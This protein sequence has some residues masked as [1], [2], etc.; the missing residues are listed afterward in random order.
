MEHNKVII[1]DRDGVI[2]VNSDSY[3]KSI[4]ELT[5]IPGS[6]NA[7]SL[8]SQAGFLIFVVSNQ[9]AIGRGLTTKSNVD[10]INN[11]ISSMV[12]K[13][14]GILDNF[15]I[16]P[17]EPK[18]ECECRK[19]KPGMLLQIEK[20]FSL[21]LKKSIFIGDAISDIK[22]AIDYGLCPILVRTG[23]GPS[24]EKESIIN[25]NIPI[26]NNLF[27]AVKNYIIQ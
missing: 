13:E 5:L 17:H 26:F 10:I 3:I 1:L 27:D 16:C 6:I 20:D 22:L 21:N 9:S 8:L 23:H 18:D 25:E 7:I 19:P 14:N 24:T 11:T 15:Y 2:N 12:R 4:D